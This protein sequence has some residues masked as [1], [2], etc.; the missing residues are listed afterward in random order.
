MAALISDPTA[1]VR[2]VKQNTF[3]ALFN[4]RTSAYM[5]RRARHTRRRR[6]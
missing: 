3:L 4:I 1:P 6:L 5:T 2:L